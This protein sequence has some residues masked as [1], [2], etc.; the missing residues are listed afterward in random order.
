MRLA[1]ILLTALIAM[2]AA[3]LSQ[4]IYIWQRLW[5]PGVSEAVV[6]ARDIA[7]GWRVLA[8]ET[9]PNG[10]LRGF[11]VQWSALQ[12]KPVT[13]VI[14]IDGTLGRLDQTTLLADIHRL[15]AH[16]P[17]A[18]AL[19]IDYDCGTAQLAAYADFLKALRQQ[20]PAHLAIT[21]LPTWLEGRDLATLLVIPDEAVLQ[22][23]AVQ[24]PAQG[25]FD[26][27]L[28]RRWINRFD[29]LTPKPFR[30]ALPDYGTRII[31][32]EG[33][34]VIAL[35]SES[36]K[37]IG[38]AAEELLVTPSDVAALVRDLERNPPHHFAGL[39]WFRLPLAGDQR[40]WSLQTLA[41]V[42]RGQA[43]QSVVTVETRPGAAP[44]AVDVLLINRG[45]FDA[46]LPATIALPASCQLADG[47]GAYRYEG[48]K[49]RRLQT[50]FLPAHHEM[51]IGWA[52]CGAGIFHV[53]P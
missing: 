53:E 33:G 19:E 20:H 2:G 17:Q 44:G 39:A 11:A 24:S 37:L 32:N 49:F 48:Q 52:R 50:A 21:A 25:L 26:P 45:T 38:G 14:R 13:A 27:R 46:V 3:P 34:R 4:D 9:D 36:P 43:P 51:V 8:A 22:V 30:I 28:A 42:M 1:G 47:L 23:H 10:H 29:A 7:S 6:A 31:R 16:W 40:I 35:E 15:A 5:T 18:V 41:Q 12:G